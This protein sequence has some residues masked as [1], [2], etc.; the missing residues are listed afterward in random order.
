[1]SKAMKFRKKP[2]VIEAIAASVAR[3]TKSTDIVWRHE[4]MPEI[5]DD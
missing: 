5:V 2:V 4:P 3:R 1:M